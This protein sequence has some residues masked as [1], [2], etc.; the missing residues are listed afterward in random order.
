MSVADWKDHSKDLIEAADKYG[1]NNL[2]LVAEAWYVKFL[3]M[4]ADDVAETLI[5]AEKMNCFLKKEA[6]IDFIVA[7]ANEV[8]ASD[9]IEDIPEFKSII[10][11]ILF[12]GC[13]YE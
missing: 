4:K 5:Y 8:L 12:F 1:V 6:A 13:N 2:K 10:L 3:K 11:E 9:A 7:N